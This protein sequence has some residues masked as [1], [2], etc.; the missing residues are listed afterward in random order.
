VSSRRPVIGIIGFGRFGN[1]A[2][3]LCARIATVYVYDPRFKRGRVRMAGVSVRSIDEVA[4]QEV[5]ILA[6]PVSAL[7]SVLSTIAPCVR[8]GSL[9]VDV[10]AVKVLPVQWMKDLL[11][12][13]VSI[14]GSHP[15]FGP[16]TVHDSAK[17]HRIVLV[18]ARV[19]RNALRKAAR[20]LRSHGLVVDLMSADEHDR[21]IAQTL[22]VTQFVGRMVGKAQLPVWN[23]STRTYQ[24][25][26]GLVGVAERDSEQLLLDMWKFNPYAPRVSRAL[27]RS[28]LTLL[29]RIGRSASR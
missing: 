21:M 19:T 12:E 11:P 6:V 8:P 29:Q 7:S 22:L 9:I 2:A 27:L 5:V 17:G 1:V 16:D 14:I 26:R 24:T 4:S 10:C 13:S 23:G 18:P 3:R 28:H 20:F 15:L 25:L